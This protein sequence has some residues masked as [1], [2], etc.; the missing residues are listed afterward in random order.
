MAGLLLLLLDIVL[1]A[2]HGALVFFILTGWVWPAARY[3]H[4]WCIG[5]TLGCW[6]AAGWMVGTAGYCPLTDWHWRVKEARGE[7]ALPPT[8]IDYVLQMVGMRADPALVGHATIGAFAAVLAV[9]LFLWVREIVTGRSPRRA[10]KE[11]RAAEK[12]RPPEAR[13]PGPR[14]Y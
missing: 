5:L 7:T 2:V 10:E 12:R 13:K 6:L 4:R 1:M 9:T 14:R 11:R 3:W 8:F